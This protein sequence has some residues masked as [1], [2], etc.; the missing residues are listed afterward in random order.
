MAIVIQ[1]LRG[2]TPVDISTYLMIDGIILL[3]SI[4]FMTGLSIALNVLLRNK[5]L[6][7]VVS[8]GMGAGLFY[9]Y[10]IGHNHWLYNPLLYQ[11]WN[12]ADLTA[13]GN[14]QT[15]IL[16]H[17]IYCFAIAGLALA[18]A[19]LFFQ[20]SAAKKILIDGRLTGAGWSLLLA[21]VSVAITFVTGWNI[22]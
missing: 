8:V 18:I 22:V 14:N 16:V 10:S 2:H 6:V 21:L 3:P 7:Y 4:V 1:F 15:T 17:R 12:Y 9:L 20:R 19:H 5:Y 11:L 13:A